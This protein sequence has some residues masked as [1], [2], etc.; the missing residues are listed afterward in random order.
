MKN[1]RIYNLTFLRRKS[2]KY[3][4]F[5]FLLGALPSYTMAI[6]TSVPI[7]VQQYSIKLSVNNQPLSQ[8]LKAISKQSGITIAYSS[9]EIALSSR[10]SGNIETNN[11]EQALRIVLGNEYS[12][13]K[14]NDHILISSRQQKKSS[15]TKK[16]QVTGLI[17]DS[18]GNPI[19]GATVMIS[20]QTTGVIS[21]LEGRYTIMANK[22]DI[23]EFR[24]IGF[25]TETRTIMIILRLMCV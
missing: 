2:L 10:F 5:L 25:V 3:L 7:S 6:A 14:V 17:T 8:V 21:D 20:E 12:F 19:P 15:V 16:M 11:I 18:D 23:L 9:D 4:V 22:G 13:R 1:N 24:Y